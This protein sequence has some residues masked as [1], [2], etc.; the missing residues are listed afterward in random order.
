MEIPEVRYARNGDVSI[1]Y[2][3]AGEGSIDL[4]YVPGY[5]SHVEYMWEGE[6]S[7]RFLRRLSSFSRLLLVDRRGTGLSDR[8]SPNDLP[9]VSR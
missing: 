3:V 6:R 2:S 8:L 4:V 9:P 5:I 7:A 1:A